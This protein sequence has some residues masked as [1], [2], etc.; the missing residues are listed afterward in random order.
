MITH[1]LD[2]QEILT[3]EQESRLQLEVSKA[4]SAFEYTSGRTFTNK[5]RVMLLHLLI[6]TIY[7][8][9]RDTRKETR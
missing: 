8:V 7:E 2:T 3:A 6:K 4:M 5:E 1:T 9:L